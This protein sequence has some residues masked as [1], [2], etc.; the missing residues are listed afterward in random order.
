MF[1]PNDPPFL[2]QFAA[3]IGVHESVLV[4]WVDKFPEFAAAY[5][6]AKD[7]FKV[8]LI[9]NGLNRTADASFSIFTAKN[10]TDMKDKTEID[11][12]VPFI[13]AVREAARIRDER[14]KALLLESG[15]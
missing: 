12:N 13:E 8:F 11:V 2:F 15:K 9:T 14:N 10:T 7:L 3:K 4:D 5:A 6:R 1:F